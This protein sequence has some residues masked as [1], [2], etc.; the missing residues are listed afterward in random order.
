MKQWMRRSAC[1]LTMTL[2]ISQLSMPLVSFASSENINTTISK[3]EEVIIGGENKPI[4][5][6]T[7]SATEIKL[8]EKKDVINK[9]NN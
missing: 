2:M 3:S 8:V 6:A 4:T 7:G 5:T 1:I 9:N